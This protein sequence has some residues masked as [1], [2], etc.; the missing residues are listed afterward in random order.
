[1]WTAVYGYL[2]LYNELLTA[3]LAIKTFFKWRDMTTTSNKESRRSAY[4]YHLRFCQRSE[5]HADITW[6]MTKR[7]VLIKGAVSKKI[8]DNNKTKDC[9]TG[10]ERFSLF[11]RIKL[12]WLRNYYATC[13]SKC[14][15]LRNDHKMDRF[16][17]VMIISLCL[18]LTLFIL[19]KLKPLLLMGP[20]KNRSIRP[21]QVGYFFQTDG[22]IRGHQE[23][24]LRFWTHQ[25]HPFIE[26]EEGAF[27][28]QAHLGNS[29]DYWY[30]LATVRIG[31]LVHS[32]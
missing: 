24:P 22:S 28:R 30:G 12:I 15:Y 3:T 23:I 19:A 4:F 14:T 26:L 11:L 5:W 13:F 20:N 18:N 21:K 8:H 10:I 29:N 25:Q 6:G 9:R 31:A 32:T 17:F 2:Y 1:M 27:A 7:G 16:T